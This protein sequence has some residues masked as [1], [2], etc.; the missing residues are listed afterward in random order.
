MVVLTSS[1]RADSDRTEALIFHFT[2]V[3]AERK[4]AYGDVLTAEQ[5]EK[6]D[7]DWRSL[8]AV[9]NEIFPARASAEGCLG[10]P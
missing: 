7:L 3:E 4:A 1:I 9:L 6:L 5:A 8:N 10:A 2:K